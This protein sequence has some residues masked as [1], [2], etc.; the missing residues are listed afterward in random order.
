LLSQIYFLS[1]VRVTEERY[2]GSASISAFYCGVLGSTLGSE[3]DSAPKSL[4]EYDWTV[5]QV[6]P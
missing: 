2:D 3:T 6:M 4:Q 5:T 1:L